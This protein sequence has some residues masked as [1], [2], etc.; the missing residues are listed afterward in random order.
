MADEVA[1]VRRACEGWRNHTLNRAAFVLGQIVS[2]GLL[3]E[4]DVVAQLSAAAFA[5]GRH[6]L[7]IDTTIASG[8]RAGMAIPRELV[9]WIRG[10]FFRR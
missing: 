10:S 6:E 5:V 2:A 1:Q 9:P 8:M 3:D 7:E 4:Y